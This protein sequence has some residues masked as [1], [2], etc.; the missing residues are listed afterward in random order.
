MRPVVYSKELNKEK[1]MNWIRGCENICYYPIQVRKNL[2][3]LRCIYS[4]SFTYNFQYTNDIVYFAYC[5]PYTYSYLTEFLNMLEF[6]PIK[7]EYNFL[8][9]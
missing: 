2:K 8:D 7:S 4:L 6:D 3:K 9:S 1:G 5:Y